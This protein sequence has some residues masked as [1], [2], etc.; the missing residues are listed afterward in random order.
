MNMDRTKDGGKR[1]DWL[2]EGLDASESMVY[3]E[4]T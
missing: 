4:A 3:C 1:K 2:E